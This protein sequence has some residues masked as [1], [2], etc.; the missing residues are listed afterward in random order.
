MNPGEQ[1]GIEHQIDGRWV[2]VPGF[3]WRHIDFAV[4]AVKVLARQERGPVRL[5]DRHAATASALLDLGIL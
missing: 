3:Y 2:P 4:T 1:Y 5:V